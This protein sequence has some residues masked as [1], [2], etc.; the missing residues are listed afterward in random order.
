VATGHVCATLID[1][2]GTVPS[3]AIMAAV[4]PN[5]VKPDMPELVARLS[6]TE[7]LIHDTQK[8]REFNF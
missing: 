8:E 2:N 1:K 7:N 6:E 3:K 4:G 5:V